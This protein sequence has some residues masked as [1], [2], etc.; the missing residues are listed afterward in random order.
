MM[1]LFLC[2]DAN[3]ANHANTSQIAPLEVAVQTSIFIIMMLN[4]QQI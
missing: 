4:W 2:F 3:V 1:V